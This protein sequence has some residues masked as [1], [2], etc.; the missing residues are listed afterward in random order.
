MSFWHK[1]RTLAVHSPYAEQV[2]PEEPSPFSFDVASISDTGRVRAGNEDSTLVHPLRNSAS[3][4]TISLLAVLADGMGGSNAG[5]VASRLAC[6]TIEQHLVAAPANPRSSLME[7]FRAANRTIFTEA[8]KRDELRGMGTTCLAVLVH[9]SRAWMAYV[10]DSRLYLARRGMLYRMTE[11]HTVV[12]EMVKSGLLT[13]EAA[14]YH[15]DRNV[16]S[17]ALGTKMHVEVSQWENPFHLEHA[18]RFLLCSDGLHDLLGDDMVLELMTQGAPAEAAARLIAEANARGGYDNIS[19][20]L[21]E[22]HGRESVAITEAP[23]ESGCHV[24]PPITREIPV[25]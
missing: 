12:Y 6:T 14:S 23:A 8:Q 19:A 2:P 11:D 18:D 16:L 15:P 20:I 1:L 3:G 9:G 5:E 10:G 4:K 17:R 21:I 25:D 24:T 22:V 13:V 7:A